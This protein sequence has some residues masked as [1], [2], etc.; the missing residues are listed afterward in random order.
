MLEIA[1]KVALSGRLFF[2]AGE[3]GNVR[4]ITH[5]CFIGCQL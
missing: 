4:K 5:S 2:F 1:T 3:G